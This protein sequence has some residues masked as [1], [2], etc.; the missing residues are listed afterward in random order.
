V[1]KVEGFK[2]EDY[3]VWDFLET[4]VFSTYLFALATGPFRIIELEKEKQY[5]NIPMSFYIRDSLYDHLYAV[6][7]ALFEITWK[8]MMYY[9]KL[10]DYPYPFN[11]YDQVFCPE[12]NMGA[13]ENVGCVTVNDTYVF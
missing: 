8:T 1:L 5:K 12:Y 9:D 3:L 11:K 6:K 10:F 7:D 13:M 4:K 2:P